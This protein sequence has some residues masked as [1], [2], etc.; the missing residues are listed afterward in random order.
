MGTFLTYQQPPLRA[1]E[2]RLQPVY[3]AGEVGEPPP[4][5]PLVASSLRQSAGEM[6]GSPEI[7]IPAS[8]LDAVPGYNFVDDEGEETRLV[9]LPVSI[10]RQ[11]IQEILDANSRP[12]EWMRKMAMKELETNP[13]HTTIEMLERKVEDGIS[14]I[15][16]QGGNGLNSQNEE[17]CLAVVFWSDENLVEMMQKSVNCDVVGCEVQDCKKAKLLRQ[18]LESSLRDI[19]FPPRPL[20]S[21]HQ[22][23]LRA[24]AKHTIGCDS[25]MCGVP[26]CMIFQAY[27]GDDEA[28]ELGDQDL[29]EHLVAKLHRFYLSREIDKAEDESSG[30]FIQI[31]NNIEWPS[32]SYEMSPRC[33]VDYEVR[34]FDITERFGHLKSRGISCTL[35][36]G[37]LPLYILQHG[38][39]EW[40]AST[41]TKLKDI[42]VDAYWVKFD[43]SHVTVCS[44]LDL[45]ADSLVNEL[46]RCKGPLAPA[47]MWRY[48][49]DLAI[50]MQQLHSAGILCLNFDASRIKLCQ[51]LTVAKMADYSSAVDESFAID[52]DAVQTILQLLPP[53]AVPPEMFDGDIGRHSDIWLLGSLFYHMA[54]GVRMYNE[55]RHLSHDDMRRLVR[56][57]DR[58][59]DLSGITGREILELMLVEKSRRIQLSELI[60]LLEE[61]LT[62]SKQQEAGSK[63]DE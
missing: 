34:K 30:T 33:G 7:P 12:P 46:R 15:V 53:E 59:P 55:D 44:H 48:L 40:T 24:L 35:P 29:I 51:N 13:E 45:S 8:T 38:S 62:L 26:W 3:T 47:N 63:T 21:S 1:E 56:H 17:H 28:Q 31:D 41:W 37:P 50:V 60:S 23:V 4:G 2:I 10:A 20:P 11:K 6:P 27:I 49:L 57:K 14:D 42:N 9:G 58:P 32:I 36:R 18:E 22:H 19:P 52:E 54:T 25:D 61:Q 5:S 39:Q 43:D 16:D